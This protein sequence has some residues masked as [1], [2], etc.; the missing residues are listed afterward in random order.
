MKAN[1]K[2]KTANI[3]NKDIQHEPRSQQNGKER[4]NKRGKM[5][6]SERAARTAGH[7]AW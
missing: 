2:E 6:Q 1:D 3:K 4:D 5:K 7:S